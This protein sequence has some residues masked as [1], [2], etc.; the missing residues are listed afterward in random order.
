MSVQEIADAAGTH[1]TTV[2]YHFDTKEAL[3]EAVLE[4][5]LGRVAEIQREFLAGPF[6]RDRVGFLIDQIQN[7]Y[8][9]HR[10]LARL[11]ERELL[12]HDGGESYLRLFVDPIYVPAVRGFRRAMQSG[13]IREIDA[14][15]FIHDLHVAL[16]GYFCHEPLLRR[17]RPGVDPYS[18]EA[19]IARR[20]YLSDWIFGVLS[21]D[22]SREAAGR[23]RRNVNRQL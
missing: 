12:D 23:T 15:Q 11:L 5:A 2:L 20:E 6:E 8:A 14:A 19:L 18:V 22:A 7:F 21:P 9:E 1:K 16:I 3:H 13:I 17:L 10:S 4:V